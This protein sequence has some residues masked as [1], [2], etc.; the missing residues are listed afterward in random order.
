MKKLLM[1][2]VAVLLLTSLSAC[3]GIRGRDGSGKVCENQYVLGISLIELIDPCG[4]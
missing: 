1:T 2:A 3:V 4:K